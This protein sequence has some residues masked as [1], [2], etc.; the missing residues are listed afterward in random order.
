MKK[1]LLIVFSGPSGVGKGTVLKEVEKDEELKIVYSVSMTTRQPREGEIEG[2][3]YFFVTPQEFQEAVAN[4]EMLEYARYAGNFYG[5]PRSFVEQER[6][7]GNNVLL[8]I[9]VQGAKQVMEK[10]KDCVSIFI[11]PPSLEEL[12]RRIRGRQTETEEKI[13]E[14]IAT[15]HRELQETDLYDHVIC[16]DDLQKAV[17]EVKAVIRAEMEKE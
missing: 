1:G 9:E 11:T 3:N 2:V 17:E 15:A 4:G 14:R 6:E 5:T 10:A 7:K 12:E 16:N 13:A 8:E